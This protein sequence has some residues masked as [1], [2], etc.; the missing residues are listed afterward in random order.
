MKVILLKDVRSL[1][2]AHDIKNVSDGYATNFLLPKKL[3]EIATVE[4]MKA[5]EAQREAR[6]HEQEKKDEE[7]DALV[8]LLRGKKVV[9]SARATEKGGLFK[10]IAGKDVA[11]A[12]HAEHQ[13]ELPEDVIQFPEHI[14]TVGEHV[15]MLASKKE[16]AEFGV[17]IVASDQ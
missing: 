2:Q 1:G 10:T 7:L 14:K 4:K 16:K 13:V 8:R 5:L 12:I 17:V 6:V 9:I 3:A 11:R 15:V